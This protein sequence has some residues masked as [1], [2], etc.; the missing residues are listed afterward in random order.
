MY[1]NTIM[2]K[3]VGNNMNNIHHYYNPKS[4]LKN[5]AS[6]QCKCKRKHR[7][8]QSWVIDK[9]KFKNSNTDNSKIRVAITLFI[10]FL[11]ILM[12]LAS[13]NITSGIISFLVVFMPTLPFLIL[14]LLISLL[15]K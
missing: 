12:L 7:K 6:T 15:K 14:A 4:I 13:N 8:K 3:K 5:K 1:Y 2:E 11:F 10:F 9:T